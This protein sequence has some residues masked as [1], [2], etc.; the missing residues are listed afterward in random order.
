[1]IVVFV[2]FGNTILHLMHWV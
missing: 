2:V 1:V